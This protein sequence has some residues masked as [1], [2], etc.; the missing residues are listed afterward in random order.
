MPLWVL[1][2]VASAFLQNGRT[3]LQKTLT[4]RVGIVGA[5]YARFLF[6]APWAVAVVLALLWYRGIGLPRIGV[7]FVLWALVGAVAQIA[8]TLL[9]LHLFSLRNYAVGNTFARTETVQS[10]LL[11]LILL[12]DRMHVLA[13]AG[14]LVSLA[15]LV[16]LSASRGLA[17]GAMNR[18]AAL[19]LTCGASFAVAA[20]G[21]RAAS[22]SLPETGEFLIRPAVTLAFV[23]IAQSVMLTVWIWRRGEGGIRAVL[24]EWRLES[25]VGAAGMLAS[26]G[27]FTAFTMVPVAQ[28]KAVGQVELV[29]NWL[30]ARF[31]FGE[32][33]SLRETTGITLVCA[34]I[35]L[36]V[37]GA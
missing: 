2:S 5:T 37:L 16:L 31:A 21:Y 6:A 34:G 13:V 8:G 26:L 35:V 14:I 17:G 25:L 11:G 22:L 3:A 27:W 29:F 1:I 24:R 7:T 18:A 4:P 9:L 10:A 30:T 20:I 23:T 15:G 12:G 28:V 36:L 32:R 19:G 33:P